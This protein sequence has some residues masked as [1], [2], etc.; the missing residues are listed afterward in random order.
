[1]TE[2]YAFLGGAVT[3][4]FFVASVFFLRF[5]KR[6]KDGL[7]AAFAAAFALL[8]LGQ[9]LVTLSDMT[10]EERTPLFLL[11]LTAFVIIIFSIWNKNRDSGTAR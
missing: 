11:R 7:F 6:T 1:M 9:A 10:I 5:W 3:F 4:G 2:L 8:G